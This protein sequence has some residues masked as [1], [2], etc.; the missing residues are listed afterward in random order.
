MERPNEKQLLFNITSLEI[1]SH[2]KD[3]SDQKRIN[4]LINLLS[5]L[6]ISQVTD[7]MNIY[8][9]LKESY[10]DNPW[11]Q[12]RIYTSIF[13]R[14]SNVIGEIIINLSDID[15]LSKSEIKH[16]CRLYNEI[17]IAPGNCTPKIWSK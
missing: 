7:K 8:G 10:K 14:L 16:I 11:K 5:M 13:T 2:K 12:K 9:F 15:N 1:F 3:I 6:N 17:A 4:K